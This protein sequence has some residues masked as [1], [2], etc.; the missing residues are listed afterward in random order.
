MIDA[1]AYVGTLF[2]NS[3][4][5]VSP[6]PDPLP[7]I[8]P[9]FDPEALTL[10]AVRW[11]IVGDGNLANGVGLHN[12]RLDVVIIGAGMDQAKAAM[13]LL[14]DLVHGWDEA[15]AGTLLTVAGDTISVASLEDDV[16]PS[17]DSAAEIPGRDLVQYSG[18]YAL[19]LRG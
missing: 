3:L 12:Y 7:N 8:R 19:A 6:A 9:D 11:N 18:A 17:R 10:P 15:P 5:A 16:L 4:N 1:D 13:R 2:K 14:H